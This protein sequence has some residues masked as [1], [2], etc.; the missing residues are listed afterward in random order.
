MSEKK[1]SIVDVAKRVGVSAATVSRALNGSS[2]VS[3]ATVERVRQVAG[4]MGYAL[5]DVRPGPKPGR[6]MKKKQIAFFNFIAPFQAGMEMPT[7][8][9]DL[10]SGM[11]AFGRDN[12]YDVKLH[13]VSTEAE[14]IEVLDGGKFAGF[15]LTGWPP[16]PDIQR[17]LEKRPCC[18]VMS[19]PWTPTWGDHV[20]PDHREAGMMAAEYLLRRQCKNPVMVSLSW[21]DRVFAQRKEGFVYALHKKGRKPKVI[22][23]ENQ[24]PQDRSLFPEPEYLKAIISRFKRLQCVPDGIFFDRDYTMARLYPLLVEEEIIQPE[25]TVLVGCNNQ[26]VCL[27]GIQGYPATLDV[28]YEMIGNVCMS[29]LLW[30]MHHMDYGHQVRSLIS[31]SLIS[32]K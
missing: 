20:M 23:P 1:A 7:A 19:T 3:A 27:K 31:P 4:Q 26:Q 24:I 16:H 25:K 10:Q 11:E 14:R 29:Q 22:I 9:F 30:R 2:R 28:H 13:F 21:P 32:L 8:F 5:S 18:W 17:Y 12:G 6:R 15:I